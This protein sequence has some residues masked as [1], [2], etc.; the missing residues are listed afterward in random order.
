M[1]PYERLDAWK[2]AY[3]F[4][5]TVYRVTGTFPKHELYGLTSQTRRAAMSVVLNIAEGSAKRGSREFR[6]FLDIA[7]GSLSEVTCE[8]RFARDLGFLSIQSW[9]SLEA[10]RNRV[11]VVLWK[12]YKSVQTKGR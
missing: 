1:A 4:A 5:V 2:L 6:R 3:A 8:L 7:L 10:E 12:L 9:E 11:G